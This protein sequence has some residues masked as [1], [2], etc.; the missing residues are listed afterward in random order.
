MQSLI[1]EGGIYGI[2]TCVVVCFCLFFVGGWGGE[3][4]G[5]CSCDCVRSCVRGCVHISVLALL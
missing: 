5:I 4:V 3:M 1:E 2:F